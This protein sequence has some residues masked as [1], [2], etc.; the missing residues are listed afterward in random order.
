MAFLLMLGIGF[1][2]LHFITSQV[3]SKMLNTTQ[4]NSS[5]GAVQVLN[6]GVALSNKIDYLSIIVFIGFVVALIVTGYLIEVPSVFFILYVIALV[7][8]VIVS[9][10]LSYIWEY[11]ASVSTFSVSIL[12][13]PITNFLLSNLPIFV[14]IAGGISLVI[15]YAKT[16]Q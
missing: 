15:T 5:A 2:L 9:A 6:S 11:F 7:V 16:K 10:I 8:L 4:I 13:F 12:A 14:T 1:L 3:T